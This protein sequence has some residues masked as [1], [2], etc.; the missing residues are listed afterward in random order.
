MAGREFVGALHAPLGQIQAEP[1]IVVVHR[2]PFLGTEGAKAYSMNDTDT[3]SNT[4]GAPLTPSLPSYNREAVLQWVLAPRPGLKAVA[5]ANSTLDMLDA[6]IAAGEWVS[7][8]SRKVLALVT[9][10]LA[11][12]RG[13]VSAEMPNEAHMLFCY[14]NIAY[15]RHYAATAPESDL[16]EAARGLLSAIEPVHELIK[17]LNARRPTPKFTYLGVSPRITETLQKMDLAPST[18]RLCPMRETRRTV[19]RDGKAESIVVFILEWPAGT[20]HGASPFGYSRAGHAQCEACGH[21]IRN[22]SNW[23]PLVVDGTDGRPRSMWVGRDC[24]KRLFGIQTRSSDEL[25]FE[26]SL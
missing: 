25:V 12:A 13:Y 22:P 6:S 16:K 10:G 26:E 9:N 7:G 18:V 20:V 1:Y 19:T 24:G 17:L 2:T 8:A 11:G 21:A 3:S 5:A 14:G 15:G 23:L 4:H